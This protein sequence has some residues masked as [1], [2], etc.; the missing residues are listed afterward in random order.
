MTQKVS[1]LLVD[2]IDG[3]EAHDTI[4]FGLDGARYEIDLSLQNA[5][6]LRSKLA[7]YI[8]KAR[9]VGNSGGRTTRPGK[10]AV[11]GTSNKEVR[12][13]A[14]AQGLKVNDRG[15]IPA[16]VIARYKTVNSK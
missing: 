7:S 4:Q 9:K 13:W 1:I 14:K 2:D 8:E 10:T 15:R 3:S 11:N 16:D 12:E 5:G 6:E